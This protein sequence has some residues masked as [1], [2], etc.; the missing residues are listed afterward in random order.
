[1]APNIPTHKA[2]T[3]L[4]IQWNILGFKSRLSDIQILVAKFSPII[5]ALQ[6]TFVPDTAINRNSI[7]GYQLITHKDPLNPYSRGV[8]LGIKNG[9]PFSPIPI[10]SNLNTICIRLQAP[11]KIS[12]VSLYAS[13]SLPFQDFAKGFEELIRQIP[14]PIIL[15]G[16]FNAHSTE[17]GGKTIDRRGRFLGDF[18]LAQSLTILNNGSH[19][20]I[21][22]SSG[23]TSALD[24]SISSLSLASK[25]SWNVLDDSG[26]SDHLPILVKLEHPTPIAATR[27]RW[28]YQEAD[29][30]GYQN[31]VDHLLSL[32]VPNNI[33]SFNTILLEAG[34]KFIPRTNGTPGKTAVPWWGPEVREAIKLRR[35]AL[36]TL[37]RIP[38]DDPRKQNALE[39]FKNAR[40]SARAAVRTAKTN[41]WQTFTEEIHPNTPSKVLW[42]KIKALNGEPRK[43]QFHLLLNRHYTNDPSSLADAFSYHFTSTTS[44]LNNNNPTTTNRPVPPP[45]DSPIS[46]MLSTPYNNIY[47]SDFS[48]EELHSA[49]RKV[50][51][52]S[53]GPDD[54]GYPFLKHLSLLAKTTFLD[55]INNIWSEGHIP[56]E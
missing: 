16:D 24:L 36:R 8:G 45:V 46:T 44:T 41:A 12:V 48:L 43:N 50:K 5:L 2:T 3:N 7:K 20:R 14:P 9:F 30:L 34:T 49:L 42:N 26:G 31:H 22:P 11:I 13:P 39:V 52:L 40:S 1:M 47:N 17:W 56:E 35:K 38:N 28:R 33:D 32:S 23:N 4:A 55:I 27:P 25:L 51:G 15:L 37:R 10:Q 18:T 53:S 54:I 6:E 21:C 29:W 19:T